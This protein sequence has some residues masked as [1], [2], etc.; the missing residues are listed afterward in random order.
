M[1]KVLIADDLPAVRTGTATILKEAG[2]EVI[3]AE[4]YVDI[5][6]ATNDSTIDIF[7]FDLYMKEVNGIDLTKEILEINPTIKIIVFTELEIDIHFNLLVSTGVSGFIT[8]TAS[9]TQLINAINSLL[10]KEVILP[11]SLLRQLRRDVR[12]TNGSN[13]EDKNVTL[14]GKERKLLKL[15]CSGYTNKKMAEELY[16]SQRTIEYHLTKIYSKLKVRSRIEAIQSVRK[17]GL[18]PELTLSNT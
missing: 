4:H 2:M 9:P 16:V 13:S 11:L 12:A 17:Y 18:L 1:V 15:I 8:K 14:T 7:L 5:I 3:L 10:N 6:Q